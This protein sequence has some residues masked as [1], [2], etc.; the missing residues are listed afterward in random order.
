MPTPMPTTFAADVPPFRRC[1]FGGCRY[2]GNTEQIR[3]LFAGINVRS[4]VDVTHQVDQVAEAFSL[5][6]GLREQDRRI[7]GEWAAL[8]LASES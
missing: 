5:S 8:L 2:C 7:S 4:A 1:A 3:Q 6:H